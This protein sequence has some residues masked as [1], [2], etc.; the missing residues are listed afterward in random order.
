MKTKFGAI[1][2]S[3]IFLTLISVA[4][5]QAKVVTNDCKW[6]YTA[7]VVEKRCYV[8]YNWFERHIL[9]KQNGWEPQS[10]RIR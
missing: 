2:S 8:T 3:V 10:I 7:Y 6:Y 5:A 9:L 1:I 4:P